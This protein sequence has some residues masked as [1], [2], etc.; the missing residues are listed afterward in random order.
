MAFALMVNYQTPFLAGITALA[1]GGQTGATPLTGLF[2]SVDTV[3][4]AADSVI[5]PS[6]VPPNFVFVLNNQA[7]NSLQVFGQPGDTIA[8]A[9]SSTYAATGTGVAHAVNKWGIY[10]C[11]A[12]GQWK[13]FI[14][15]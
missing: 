5:L 7:S 13:Q 15:G 9:S 4:T 12:T 14:S 6:A 8:P 3:A 1:G 10:I 11:T 2:N